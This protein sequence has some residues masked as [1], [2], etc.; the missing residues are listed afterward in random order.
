MY[1]LESRGMK[2]WR[3]IGGV[4]GGAIPALIIAS[5]MSAHEM[6]QRLMQLDMKLFMTSSKRFF[7]VLL[8]YMRQ[9]KT[10]YLPDTAIMDST[11][12]GQLLESMVPSWPKGFWTM[13]VTFLPEKEGFCQ[14][15]FTD[16]GVFLYHRDGSCE[17][18]SDK[19]ASVSLALRATCAVPGLI[20]HV[21]YM[22]M[23][24]YDGMLSWDGHCPIGM[25]TRHFEAAPQD[26]W[27]C[28][29]APELHGFSATNKFLDYWTHP[30]GRTAKIK[31]M[32]DEWERK[33]V[34]ILKAPITEFDPMDLSL[35]QSKRTLAF[36]KAWTAVAEKFKKAA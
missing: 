21:E 7:R 9:D 20:G 30:D 4:S 11:Q 34:T 19:P 12:L 17:Q 35:S 27:A 18:L 25:V 26:I 28:D 1:G 8:S 29:V 32:M 24:L 2:E 5:G 31:D 23:R 33:G 36:Q 16:H 6:M 15:L 3:T 13:A 14:V 22:G 10:N